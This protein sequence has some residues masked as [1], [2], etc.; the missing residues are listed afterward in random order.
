MKLTVLLCVHNG[1]PYLPFAV[2]SI[3]VQTYSDFRFL[4]ID[5]HSLDGSSE[6]LK[7]LRDN[8]IEIRNIEIIDIVGAHNYGLS[9]INTEYTAIMDA[10]DYSAIDRLRKQIIFLESNPLIGLLGTSISY[11]GKSLS[12]RWDHHFPQQ[13]ELIMQNMIKGR[14]VLAHPSIM[15]R[16][17]LAK[18]INGYRAESVPVPDLDFFLRFA[19]ISRIANLAEIYHFQRILPGSYTHKNLKKVVAKKYEILK[20]YCSYRSRY[21][22]NYSTIEY[23]SIQIY[24]N[25]LIKYLDG[26]RLIWMFY[27]IFA[28]ILDISKAIYRIKTLYK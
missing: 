18:S 13:H 11:I 14:F 1:M 20:Y 9:L 22:F 27:L 26:S 19:K 25:G 23:M 3:L 10:D 4:I 21:H 12:T 7:T 2:E 8:R 17:Q 6:Y 24:K 16:T 28:G 5:N 15:F